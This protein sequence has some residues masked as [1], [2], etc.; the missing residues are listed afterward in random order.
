MAATYEPI[1]ST[2]LSTSAASYEFTSIPGT[3]TDLIL[4]ATPIINVNQEPAVRFNSDSGSN[5][6][7][8]LLQGN[9]T[10][11]S[12]GRNANLTW[13][14]PVGNGTDFI[15]HIQSYS[16]TN[17]YKTCLSSSW[18]SV[19]SVTRGV[20]LWRS[21]SAITSIWIGGDRAGSWAAGS[22]FSLYGI[23]AA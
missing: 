10:A 2:V 6:S 4:V 11:A 3:F 13:A 1:A 12:S 7:R 21:T 16:N 22:T 17:V 9:G 8:T 20:Q 15:L 18:I 14:L 5:Y 23:K 19:G